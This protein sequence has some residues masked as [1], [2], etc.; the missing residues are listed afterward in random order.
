MLIHP[1]EPVNGKVG[2]FLIYLVSSAP[3]TIQICE[4][5]GP[6]LFYDVASADGMN[7]NIGYT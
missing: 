2:P 7:G 1:T 6:T 5:V 4:Y 3:L